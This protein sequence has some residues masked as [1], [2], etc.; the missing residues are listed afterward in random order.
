[1][2]GAE[3]EAFRPD[4]TEATVA[5]LRAGSPGASVSLKLVPDYGHLDLVIGKNAARDVFPLILDHLDTTT[6]S[7][8]GTLVGA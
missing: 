5:A 2:H 8:A 3:S 1:V 6:A 4:G 7:P